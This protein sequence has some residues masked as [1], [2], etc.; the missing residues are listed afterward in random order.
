[1]HLSLLDLGIVYF[2]FSSFINFCMQLIY[3]WIY[4][5][6]LATPLPS[7]IRYILMDVTSM[8]TLFIT[9]CFYCFNYF[10][11]SCVNGNKP[12]IHT[13]TNYCYFIYAYYYLSQVSIWISWLFPV[14]VLTLQSMK[15]SDV[16]KGGKITW[17]VCT[18][19]GITATSIRY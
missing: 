2:N 3:F 12:S 5:S 8:C 19:S 10:V 4:K 11:S 1:M 13:K 7:Y 14:I 6:S 18:L 17:I 15:R 9:F 16:N